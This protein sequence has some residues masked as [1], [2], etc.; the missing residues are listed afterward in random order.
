MSALVHEASTQFRAGASSDP[1]E[2]DG[3]LLG[4]CARPHCGDL[5]R[6]EKWEAIG[7][8]LALIANDPGRFVAQ[9]EDWIGGLATDL[10]QTVGGRP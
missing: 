2:I 3:T 8:S 6:A 1:A 9:V 4:H 7:Q 5:D 10:L